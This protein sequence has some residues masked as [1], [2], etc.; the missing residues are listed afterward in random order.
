M[1][2]RACPRCGGDLYRD[3]L[4]TDDEYV[5]LQCGRRADKRN[6]SPRDQD[7]REQREVVRVA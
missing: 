4:E 6:T 5:C 3:M 2:M 1:M 7:E